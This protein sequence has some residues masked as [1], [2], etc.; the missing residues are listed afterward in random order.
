MCF[1]FFAY[2]AMDIFQAAAL[3]HAIG[4]PDRQLVQAEVPNPSAELFYNLACSFTAW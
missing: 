2:R 3:D 1:V 4:Y